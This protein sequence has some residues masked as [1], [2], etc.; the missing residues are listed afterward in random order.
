M[1][2]AIMYWLPRVI[3]MLAILFA[4][5]FAFDSFS[6]ANSIWQQ[7][8]E[9]LIHLIP[10]YILLIVLLIAWKFELIGGVI[11][12]LLSVGFAPFIFMHN[13]QMNHSIGICLE[14]VM[15]INFPFLLAGILFVLDHK[16]K[17]KKQHQS[18]C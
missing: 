10:S 15:L 17:N 4:S 5:V 7:L 6:T 16:N 18:Q 1:K 2:S 3:V 11:F 13:Y 8:L 14:I 12:I 9:F